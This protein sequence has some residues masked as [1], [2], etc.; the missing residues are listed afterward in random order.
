MTYGSTAITRALLIG[1][2]SFLAGGIVSLRSSDLSVDA[3]SHTADLASIDYDSYDV[4]VNAAYDPSFM[5]QPYQVE[6]DFD[7]KVVKHIVRSRAHYVM[8]SSRRVYGGAAPFRISEECYPR[9]DEHYGRN[10]L[11]TETAVQA[12][13]GSRCTILR[14]ANVFGYELGRRSF[15]GIALRTLKESNRIVLD[16]SPFVSRDFI[17]VEDFAFLLRRVLVHRPSG[18]Y[19]LGSG[20]ATQLGRIALWI[21]EGYQGGELLVTSPV[22]RDS[23]VLDIG[24]LA[25]SIESLGSAVDI[26]ARCIEIGRKLR[27]A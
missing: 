15:F 21:I 16:I 22:E 26:H 27:D 19:N 20:C 17:Y 1:K 13:L 10:K 14:V 2:G 4:V 6:S 25:S 5:T 11:R 7:Y 12:L 8:L 24:K 18:I 23:F 9:P 3:L